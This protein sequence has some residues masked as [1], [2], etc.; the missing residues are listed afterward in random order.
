[1][2]VELTIE[3]LAIVERARLLLGPGL[4]TL[5]GETGAGKSLLGGAVDLLTG[6]RADTDLIRTGADTARVEGR[7]EVGP[8]PAR[9]RTARLLDAWG[10]DFDEGELVLRREIARGGRSRV[11]INQTP[12]TLSALREIG[13]ALVDVHGQHE[14][15]SLLRRDAQRELL[16][17]WGGLMPAV[18]EHGAFHA[19]WR[20]AEN[21]RRDFAAEEKRFADEADAWAFAHE[22]LEGARLVEGEDEEL[23]SKLARLRHSGRLTQALARARAALDGGEEDRRAGALHETAEAERGLREAAAIDPALLVLAEELALARVTL[24]E[25]ARAVETALDPARLDPAE[26][27]AAEARHALLE[28]LQRKYRR[29]LGER[30]AWRDELAR[31]LARGRDR[32]AERVRLEEAVRGARAGLDRAGVDLARRRRAAAKKLEKRLAPELAAVGLAQGAIAIAF[33]AL[34]EPAPEGTEQVEMRFAPNPGEEARPLARIASG[35]ELSRV[36]LALKTL[37]AQED[38][39]DL[40]LFDEVDSGIGGA[41]ARA[42]GERLARLGQVRQVLCVTHLPVIACQAQ[43]QFRIVRLVEGGRTRAVVEP[44]EGEDRIG[45][46]ARML[47]GD[48]A[49]ET[50]R[51]QARELLR[52]APPAG[53]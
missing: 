19:A 28:R 40:L 17:R 45:E 48:A 51:R 8:G 29:P 53:S 32:D 47:A 12:V 18:E 39:V 21:T 6:G 23:A 4:M 49:T 33:E 38:G 37:L 5:S 24:S 13:Q 15:Q 27:E 22:E 35:G 50:T 3:D 26:A 31:R 9:K 20:A 46:I 16:D 30:L 1:M 25:A 14:H 11:W 10:I 41:V 7:F 34:A 43:R 52:L 2:L 44:V 36:M 42:V